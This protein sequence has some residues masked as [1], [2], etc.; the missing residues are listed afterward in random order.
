MTDV[1]TPDALSLDPRSQDIF[2]QIVDAYLSNGEPIG[3]RSISRALPQPLSPAS[4]RNVMADLEDAGLIYAPH[5]SAGRLPT[6]QG[7]RFF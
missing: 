6:D 5:T 1:P 2:R 4:V 3:S 7:L